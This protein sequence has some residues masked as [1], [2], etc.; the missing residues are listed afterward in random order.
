MQNVPATPDCG[1][2]YWNDPTANSSSSTKGIR[3]PRRNHRRVWA[4]CGLGSASGRQGLNSSASSTAWGT[5]TSASPSSDA[6]PPWNRCVSTRPRS[7]PAPKRTL[8][9][10]PEPLGAYADAHPAG[11]AER[12]VPAGHLSGTGI[13]EYRAQT[14]LC[15]EAAHQETQYPGTRQAQSASQIRNRLQLAIRT[16]SL[17]GQ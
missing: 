17:T 16:F 8:R 14:R 11:S 4:Y 12:A 5:S 2:R 3:W 15:R 9:A 6:W 10:R 13:S 1:C 7:R